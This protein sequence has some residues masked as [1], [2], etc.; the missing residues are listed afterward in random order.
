MKV[1]TRLFDHDG[2]L[3]ELA[4]DATAL[5]WHSPELE[6]VGWGEALR[7]QPGVGAD[8]VQRA[9]AALRAAFAASHVDD[10]VA[11]VASGPVAIGSFSFGE[12]SGSSVLVVPR[13]L[14]VRTARG[15]WCTRV[16]PDGAPPAAEPGAGTPAQARTDRVRYA[17]S[18]QPDVRWLAAVA[19]AVDAVEAGVLDKVVLA[20][21]HAVWSHEPF[22]PRE[23][24]ARLRA[25]FPSCM[26]FHVDGLVGASP[27]LLARV[28]GREVTSRVLAGTTATSSD[29]DRDA[30]L[31]AAL[32][33]SD[34][35]L[36]EHA[37]AAESVADVLAPLVDVLQREGPRTIRLDNVHHLA[38]EVRGTLH[39]PL[40]AL[41]VAGML[42][43]TAAVGGTPTDAA[44]AMIR[45]LE[46]MDR[47][48]YAG[49]VGWID[50]RGDGDWAI[51]LRCA[52]VS[53]ARA[54]LFAGVGI[55]AGSLP[56]D[57]LEETRLKLR[58]MQSAL[59]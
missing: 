23:L 19:D 39:A 46:G 27:E 36:R 34:K 30:A 11:D 2:P 44:L 31:A 6:M 43:P 15:T 50:A 17:G 40:D 10:E 9:A 29:P 45:R 26:V 52:E 35:D 24:A 59:A 41:A 47:G 7:V 53:G 12:R 54:R 48:R 5:L 56:E 33:G 22:D 38:T 3:R 20:R 28:R 8:R 32:L 57:E 51:A 42:H 13:V 18:S 37:F 55:V 58:A 16:D 49:P 25:R 4:P 1:T 14:L 21:D